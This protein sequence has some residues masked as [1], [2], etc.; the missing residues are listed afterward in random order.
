M[1]LR[2]AGPD[3]A[4]LFFRLRNDPEAI[5]ASPGR[6]IISEAEHAEWW[7]SGRDLRLVAEDMSTVGILRV[8]ESGAVSIIVAP[9]CR[10][11]GYGTEMLRALREGLKPVG[12]T[13]TAD[14]LPTNLRSQGAFLAAGWVPTRFV[15]P[16]TT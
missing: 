10:G 2:L 6:H 9:E 4:D 5:D 13:L 12:P 3:D 8:S 14:V 11:C 16:R 15:C 1:K 7:R